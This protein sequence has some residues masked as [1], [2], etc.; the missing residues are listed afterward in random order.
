MSYGA[1]AVGALG[2]ALKVIGGAALIASMLEETETAVVAQNLGNKNLNRAY[3]SL[4]VTL[5]YSAITATITI[6]I[7]VLLRGQ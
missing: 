6:S 3:K 1:E 4:G 5:V 7:V 2:I